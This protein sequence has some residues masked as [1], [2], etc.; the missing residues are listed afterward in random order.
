[1]AERDIAEK[2]LEDA[3]LR[4]PFDGMLSDV[5]VDQFQKVAPGTIV[6]RLQGGDG[7]RV[8]IN[9][10][11]GRVALARRMN[12]QVRHVVRFDFL[13]ER[14]FDATLAEFTTEADA[15]TQTFRAFFQIEPPTDVVIL[16]G[17]TATVIEIA[18]DAIDLAPGVTVPLDAVVFDGSGGQPFVWKV[19]DEG[20]RGTATVA[21]TPITVAEVASDRVRIANGLAEGTRV[22]AAGVHHLKDGQRVR[23]VSSAS[24]ET[25]R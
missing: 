23:P 11:A 1:M 9:V 22:A 6:A 10:D 13:P 25:V 7:V 21:R 20:D 12:E 17:M 18:K 2:S 14:E 19:S 16:P 4:A 3:T 15:N 8:E 5:F 24:P